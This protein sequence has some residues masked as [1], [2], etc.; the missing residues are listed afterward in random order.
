MEQKLGVANRVFDVRTDADLWTQFWGANPTSS[1]VDEFPP[2]ARKSILRQWTEAFTHLPVG[3]NL[4]DI[5][6]GRGALLEL[7]IA[8]GG[9]R[10][11]TEL[12]GIDSA[13]VP[14]PHPPGARILSGTDANH[15]PFADRGVTMVVS[16]FGL[17]YAGLS[18][19]LREAARVCQGSLLALV[20]AA[21]GVVCRQMREQAEQVG[22]L[23]DEQDLAGRLCASG[24]E[25][26]ALVAAID[27]RASAAENYS[28]LQ[29]MRE[30]VV[31]LVDARARLSPA[32]YRA[33]LADVIA[34]MAAHRGRMS[35]L[36]GA[37]PDA[38]DVAA[39]LAPLPALGFSVSVREERHGD[40]LVGRWIEAR[41]MDQTIN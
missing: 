33:M 36:A 12:T 40:L 3:A 10:L 11:D 35:L 6:C 30:C 32:D 5:G 19:A 41:R 26:R 17:E 27:I 39:A 16:Q 34:G 9:A 24:N 15:L 13:Y 18:S 28:L 4:L 8:A 31:A 21:D 1:C 37:A 38:D 23:L 25:A 22:W 7:A 20:H 29:H 14:A 2:S